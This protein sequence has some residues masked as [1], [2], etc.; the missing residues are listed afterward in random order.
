MKPHTKTTK[1]GLRIQTIEMPNTNVVTA[2]ILVGAGSRNEESSIAGI[3]HFLEHMFFK[4]GEKYPTPKS[5]SA[6]IDGIGGEFNAFTGKET[7]GY[8]VKCSKEHLE[9]A[10]SV[11]SDMLLH[12]TFPKEEIEKERGVILEEMAMYLDTPIY[13]ISFDFERVL[14]GDQP[15]GR[16]EIGTR[17]TVS[18][19]TRADFLDYK[20]SLYV[21]ESIVITLA[22]AVT[23]QELELVEQYFPFEK[24]GRTRHPEAF[25][26]SIVTKKFSL[27]EKNTEQYHIS[28]G[29][30]LPLGGG[31]ERIPILRVLSVI[32]GGNMSS[33]MF[34]NVREEKG[35]CY[36]IGTTIDA[37][38][39]TGSLTTRA[40][41]RLN[42]VLKALEAI[43]TEYDT[44][45]KDGV[46]DIELE[47]AKAYLHGK[48]D[49]AT[50]DTERVAQYYGK[51]NLL[52]NK[53]TDFDAL[54]KKISQVTKEEVNALARELFKPEHYHFAG[55]GPE[56]D[57]KKLLALIS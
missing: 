3:A 4:G 28:M 30:R 24:G 41:V 31:D 54:K 51:N 29:V 22:G 20:K 21:P 14:F 39:E 17:E 5:V 8:Y 35:L 37:Y 42:D 47:K 1:D 33:R 23:K 43:R 56:V 18:S 19:V 55:I 40:G 25:N 46:T 36:S 49:L 6:T 27:R 26:K 32:L 44:I 45:A 13:Q 52:Y 11:L 38:S 7:V 2:L 50:E 57:E 53:V 12:A 16:D 48:T 15:L 34:Q 10:L 9:I